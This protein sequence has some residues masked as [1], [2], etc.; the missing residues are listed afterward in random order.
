M[1][2]SILFGAISL[3]SSKLETFSFAKDSSTFCHL[4]A[5]LQRSLEAPYLFYWLAFF[6]PSQT[7]W[8]PMIMSSWHAN[9][10]HVKVNLI[11]LQSLWRA[12]LGHLTRAIFSSG[13]HLW[14]LPF[15]LCLW[16]CLEKLRRTAKIHQ[17]KLEGLSNIDRLIGGCIEQPP[18]PSL[19]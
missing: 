16:I 11:E 19:F 17:S 8:G 18:S 4:L 3:W 12:W 7:L 15:T 13:C 14:T 6:G 9:E 10:F 2:M 1:G 5:P